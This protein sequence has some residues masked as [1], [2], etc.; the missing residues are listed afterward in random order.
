MLRNRKPE[1]AVM[2]HAIANLK[3]VSWLVGPKCAINWPQI[4]TVK[5]ATRYGME[6]MWQ[7]S[8]FENP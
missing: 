4:G 5:E 7:A 8:V 3:S 2:M 6:L 1:C